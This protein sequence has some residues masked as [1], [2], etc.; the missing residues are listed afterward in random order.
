[1]TNDPQETMQAG[2][3]AAFPQERRIALAEAL[4]ERFDMS[5]EDA[6][7]IAETMA[8]VFGGEPEVNDETLD[9]S[10]RSI[11]YTLEAKKILTFRRYEYTIE[12]GER[13]RG[14]AWRIRDEAL[15]PSATSVPVEAE[16]D[17]Y[18]NLPRDVWARQHA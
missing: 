8:E 6:E 17:V 12:T 16:E 13:R 9:P 7:A 3:T 1:M 2:A 10:I 5:A 18:A 4:R 11:F 15:L 14:F